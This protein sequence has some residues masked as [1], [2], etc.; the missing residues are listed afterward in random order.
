MVELCSYKEEVAHERVVLHAFHQPHVVCTFRV[1]TDYVAP[2]SVTV[3]GPAV[4]RGRL[5][6]VAGTTSSSLCIVLVY[7]GHLRRTSL[8]SFLIAV[9]VSKIRTDAVIQYSRWNLLTFRLSET[10]DVTNFEFEFDNVRTSHVFNRFEI[11]RM[12]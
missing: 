2:K 8:T 11:C 10:R 7:N 5:K 12:F 4:R 6:T 1:L 3:E 9:N